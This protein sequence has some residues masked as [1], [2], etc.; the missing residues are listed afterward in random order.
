MHKG[1]LIF[2]TDGV[3]DKAGSGFLAPVEVERLARAAASVLKAPERFPR[4]FPWAAGGSGGNSA[5][6]WK[7]LIGRDTRES[8]PAIGAQ[9]GGALRRAGFAVIDL[10]VIP[11]PGVAHLAAA[12]PEAILG[13]VVSASHNPAEYNG[14]K[15]L[16]TTG[17]KVT[18]D[19]EKAVSDAY[20]RSEAPAAVPEAPLEEDPRG[21]DRYVGFLRGRMRHGTK[22]LGRKVVLDTAHGA[23]FEA[24]PR[25]FQALGAEVIQI[26]DLPD[27]RNINAVCGALHPQGLARK[28][29]EV[30]ADFGFAFDGDGDRMI[31]VARD[32]QILDGDHV[33][34]IA[35]K[36]FL[37]DGLLPRKAVVATVM[38]NIGLEKA[39]ARDGIR[40]IRTP[41][42]DRHVHKE[43]V[44][45][46][47]PIGGEQS[48][49]LIFLEDSPTGDGILAAMR[50]IDCLGGDV[51][52]L[53]AE[54]RCMVRFP[55]ILLNYKVPRRV[56][57]E[58]LP[59][60]CRA[61]REAEDALG[62]EGRVLLRY[63]GT[64]P[65][66]RVMIEGPEK[67]MI[68]R[69][70]RGIGEEILRAIH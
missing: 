70:A 58:S 24:A 8:G 63:S 11:T 6:R 1:D 31:P 48:G 22:L 25:L 36:R 59:G 7:V 43:M 61:V 45:G 46:A 40:L 56:P 55:Q 64:E 20:W 49:H 14:I 34:A 4:D 47:H 41:V 3:R 62:G 10:A 53:A 37:A 16:A 51:P 57:L 18:E 35:G 60:V 9:M 17:A 15:F 69:L 5:R 19:L 44:L 39:L 27:G 33:L 21:L 28:V 29:A 30:G 38:S 42:G 32:G 50:L 67:S 26:G 23:T 2:G 54:A 13:V 68:E 66:A 52:D 12:E 65:L